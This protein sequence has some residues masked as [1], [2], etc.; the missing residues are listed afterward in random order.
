MDFGLFLVWSYFKS[1]N[2]FIF[3]CW[4]TCHLE[5]SQSVIK[6]KIKESFIM[7]TKIICF[8]AGLVR[9]FL[10]GCC[11][12]FW[13]SHLQHVE[14]PRPAVKSKLQLPAYAS[15]TALQDA[16]CICNLH[17]SSWQHRMLNPL[18]EARDRTH[19]LIDTSHVHNLM[20]H[21]GNFRALNIF[22]CWYALQ[23]SR[24]ITSVPGPDDAMVNKPPW[25]VDG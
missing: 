17:H 24:N 8:P 14:V 21:D 19:I 1:T 11:F 16:S 12:C 7:Q 18:S 23:L 15:A 4:R 13:G 22:M 10:L 2:N 3:Q 9:A 5:V 20:C 6:H 25:G